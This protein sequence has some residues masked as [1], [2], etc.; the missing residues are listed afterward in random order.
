MRPRARR[1]ASRWSA[2][3]GAKL[4]A[5]SALRRRLRARIDRARRTRIAGGARLRQFSR[6]AD[7][8]FRQPCGRRTGD[9]D[10]SG[11]YHAG[12]HAHPDRRRAGGHRLRCRSGRGGRASNRL[13]RD[14][15]SVRLGQADR[16]LDRWKDDA[17]Q[18]LPELPQP[19][20]LATLQYTGGTTG[21]PKGVNLTHRQSALNISQREALIDSAASQ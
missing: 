7:R 2:A 9:A 1:R 14:S 8:G 11:L 16:T 6:H 21:L 19:D 4:C 20:S 3:S 18:R 17:A 10:Q 12:T 13:T 15:L 5:I